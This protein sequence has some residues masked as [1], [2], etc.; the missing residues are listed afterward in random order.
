LSEAT[1]FCGFSLAKTFQASGNL[2][3]ARN[4]SP[5]GIAYLYT[6]GDFSLAATSFVRWLAPPP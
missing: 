3:K 5:P 2:E 4:R 1:L 6:L